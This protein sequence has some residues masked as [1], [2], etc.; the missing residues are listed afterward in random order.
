M[1][2]YNNP[3]KKKNTKAWAPK[4]EKTVQTNRT[5]RK[6]SF[7]DK[8]EKTAKGYYTQVAVPTLPA[9]K[10]YTSNGAIAYKSSGSALLDI[11]TSISAL[12]S[13]PDGDV[14]K[15]F[16]AAY[17]EN[18]RLAIRWLFYAG[19]IREGQGERRLFKICLED[20]MNN[21]GAQIV[22]NLIP[23]IPEYSR[24]D[25]IYAVMD[26]P[27][28]R[29][30]V[31]EL[32]RKQ[33][34]EDMA[35]MKKGKSISLMAKWLDSASSHSHDTRK[36]GLKTMDMLG[37]TE[38]EYRK[39]LSA[40][41]KHLDVVER[42][43]SSQNWQSID[44][45]T[46]PSKA[47]LN[48][49]N[50]FLRNDEERRRAYLNALTKGEAKI[51]SSVANPCDIVHKYCD[52]SWNSAP[53]SYD[54]TLEGMWK[55]LPN[56]VTDDSS[57]IVVADGSGSMCTNVG[58]T[59]LTALE[60]ANS[61]AIYFAERAKGAY[62]GRYITFSSR[63]QMVNVNHDSLRENLME[64]ARHNEIDNTNLE[65]VFDL[66]LETAIDNHSPQSDLPKNILIISDGGWDSMVNIRN[67][68]TGG[69]GYG[70]YGYWGYNST[71]ATAQ[72]A[73]AF[74][75]SIEQKYKDAGYEMSKIIFWNVAGA[76]NTGNGL[77]MT[78]NDY[79]IMVSGFSVNTLKAVLSGKMN[80]WDALMEVVLD[81]RYDKI[82][83]LAF[84]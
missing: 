76:G 60:V 18:P 38:R 77:P 19:D 21:G 3:N 33:W 39:G 52:G 4:P 40:L 72:E 36:R 10:Q 46:V 42:K 83:E 84:K 6:A 49:N 59:R 80:P 73:P 57:T 35:N 67:I 34:K 64:A 44:Y 43:M 48:Y 58:R 71:R 69:R 11:N 5:N 7:M 9:D 41:R 66:I 22:A 28:T 53:R 2:N 81:K 78:K 23:M 75:K 62:K 32:I 55:S 50:A 26:N 30:V 15:K 63:P 37:L 13:L 31:R 45:E 51:N 82:E 24:W 79:G 29:P 54:A 20:M 68:S 14:V 47:N 61:L 70:G 12:R 74:L 8:V 27:T 65:A 25:Y 17:S 56:L 1:Y 16:R